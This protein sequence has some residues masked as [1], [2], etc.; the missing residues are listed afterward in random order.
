MERWV[1]VFFVSRCL[2]VCFP[3]QRSTEIG[4][5]TISVGWTIGQSRAWVRVNR[6]Q[7]LLWDPLCFSCSNLL[8]PSYPCSTLSTLSFSTFHLLCSCALF[9][10]TCALAPSSIHPTLRAFTLLLPQKTFSI[11]TLPYRL[12]QFISSQVGIFLCQSHINQVYT[13]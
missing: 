9:C 7:R 4:V 10:S 1:F 5:E 3:W 6:C 13:T 8:C 11:T 12:H 2:F